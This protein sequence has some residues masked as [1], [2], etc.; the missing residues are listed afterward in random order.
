MLASFEQALK[1]RLH[2][3]I[4]REQFVFWCMRNTADATI[5]RR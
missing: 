5:R 2:A 4:C 1:V 3:E